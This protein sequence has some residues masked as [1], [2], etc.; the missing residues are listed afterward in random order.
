M[1]KVTQP[2]FL[3][4]VLGIRIRRIRMILGLPD[5]DP[6]QLVRGTYPDPADPELDPDPDPLGRGTAP[7]V[8]IRTKVTRILVPIVA[9]CG[10][11][12][13]KIIMKHENR[14]LAGECNLMHKKYSVVSITN[15]SKSADR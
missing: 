1:F 2:S 3:C 15:Y 4:A 12:A 5:P 10:Q 11:A 14:L 7:R 9:L 6:N 13:A 8:R